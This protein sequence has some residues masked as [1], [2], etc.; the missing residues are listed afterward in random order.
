[1]LKVPALRERP[2]DI[3]LLASHFLRLNALRFGDSALLS[4]GALQVVREHTWP[5]NVREL[6]SVLDCAAMMGTHV[7]DVETMQAALDHQRVDVPA[8]A[9]ADHVAAT[10]DERQFLLRALNMVAWDTDRLARDRGVSRATIYRHMSRLGIAPRAKRALPSVEADP[11]P[12]G[13]SGSQWVRGDQAR[14]ASG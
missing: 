5:G 8:P 3:P 7:I 6:K 2:E 13:A 1:V 4:P 14:E 10:A 9:P 11:A 12:P